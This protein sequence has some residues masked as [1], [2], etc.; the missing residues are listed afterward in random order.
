MPLQNR[1]WK[2][3]RWNPHKVMNY[4]FCLCSAV[5]IKSPVGVWLRFYHKNASLSMNPD[6]LMAGAISPHSYPS[7]LN[8]AASGTVWAPGDTFGNK[9]KR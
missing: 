1:P 6:L 4:G 9:K 3:L 2:C 8:S 7:R 5:Q